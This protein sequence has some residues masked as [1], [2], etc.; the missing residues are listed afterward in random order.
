MVNDDDIFAV[1]LAM[2]IA[3]SSL[4]VEVVVQVV[5]LAVCRAGGRRQRHRRLHCGIGHACHVVVVRVMALAVHRAGGRQ[6]QQRLRCGIGHVHCIVVVISGGGGGLYRG[7]GS[8][9]VTV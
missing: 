7:T 3:S 5:D 4:L 8:V 2:H 9:A 1:A 6:Q